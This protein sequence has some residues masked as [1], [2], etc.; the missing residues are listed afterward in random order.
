MCLKIL[1]GGGVVAVDQWSTQEFVQGRG[2]NLVEDRGQRELG[3]GCG[4]PIVRGSAL[5]ANE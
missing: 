4:S 5:F 2:S 3:L 1:F